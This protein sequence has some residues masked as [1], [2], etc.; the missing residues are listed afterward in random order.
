M[1]ID[2]STHQVFIFLVLCTL[3]LSCENNPLD[4]DVS[5]VKIDLKVKRFDQ[6]LFA[7][8]TAIT[9]T[10]VEGLTKK[11]KLFL[12]GVFL[13]GLANIRYIPPGQEI[14]RGFHSIPWF[15]LL[16]LFFSFFK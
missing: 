6:D 2:F 10:D 9:P 11:Y 12:G 16:I 3:L 13:L 15:A 14:Y 5:T 7:Y 8:K 4:V 1:K